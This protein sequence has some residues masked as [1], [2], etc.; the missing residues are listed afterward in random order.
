MAAVSLGAVCLAV[1]LLLNT[2]EHLQKLG[3]RATLSSSILKL[4][5]SQ[6]PARLSDSWR[7][8]HQNLRTRRAESE[9]VA[10]T[11]SHL[12]I[13]TV[14]QA[15]S[16][17]RCGEGIVT[18]STDEYLSASLHSNHTKKLSKYPMIQIPLSAQLFTIIF[19]SRFNAAG[20]L[21]GWPE[22]ISRVSLVDLQDSAGPS[23]V[24]ANETIRFWLTENLGR[25]YME[26]WGRMGNLSWIVLAGERVI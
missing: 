10:V 5:T 8:R 11:G 3:T 4:Q 2:T 24:T 26:M 14:H 17:D 9:T 20:L 13:W 23:R 6:S 25:V 15:S 19:A 7:M 18:L 16:H 1:S 22:V 12:I 21:Q